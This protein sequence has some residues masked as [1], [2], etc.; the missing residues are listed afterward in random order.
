MHQHFLL[1]FNQ[2]LNSGFVNSCGFWQGSCSCFF[3]LIT[4]LLLLIIY[5]LYTFFTISCLSGNYR[6]IKRC[7]LRTHNTMTNLL[8]ANKLQWAHLHIDFFLD[9]LQLKVIQ[10]DL[11]KLLENSC[12]GIVI[13]TGIRERTTNEVT[14]ADWHLILEW[15]L[16]LTRQ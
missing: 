8:N 1:H 3:F 11:L 2:F 13:L 9:L 12:F 10:F 6:V 7:C 16:V 15:L 5:E 14:Q 4:T